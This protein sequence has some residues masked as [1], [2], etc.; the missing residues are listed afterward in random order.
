MQKERNYRQAESPYM[1]M[2]SLSIL[3]F[4]LINQASS[5]IVLMHA[6]QPEVSLEHLTKFSS[7]PDQ[8]VIVAPIKFIVRNC[9][10]QGSVC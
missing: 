5:C 1:S 9:T 4:G 8:V 10:S 7:V 3:I 6:Q 2:Y